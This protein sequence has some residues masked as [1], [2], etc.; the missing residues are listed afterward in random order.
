MKTFQG[1]A[2]SKAQPKR[3]TDKISMSALKVKIK[4]VFGDLLEDDTPAPKA[5]RVSRSDNHRLALELEIARSKKRLIEKFKKQPEVK[6]RLPDIKAHLNEQQERAKAR[7]SYKST[8]E[9]VREA[10][11]DFQFPSE[12]NKNVQR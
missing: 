8:T 10:F 9:R 4:K 3:Q 12:K 2:K 1:T 5:A 6:P 7:N 11:K